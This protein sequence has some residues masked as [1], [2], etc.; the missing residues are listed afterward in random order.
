MGIIKTFLDTILS[1]RVNGAAEAAVTNAIEKASDWERAFQTGEGFNILGNS[2]KVTDAFGQVPSVFKAVMA[3]TDNVPQAEIK[4][5][6][7]NDLDG[8]PIPFDRL[9]K[10]LQRLFTKPNTTMNIKELMQF[11]AGFMS[12]SGEFMVIKVKSKGQEAGTSK[13]PAELI[14]DSPTKFKEKKDGAGKRV[15][16]VY[17]NA[18]Y[19]NDEV[20]YARNFNNVDVNRGISPNKPLSVILDTDLSARNYNKKFFDNDATPSVILSTDQALNDAQR[21]R[22]KEWWRKQFQGLKNAF[23][24]AVLEKGLKAESLGPSH[25]DMLFIKQSQFTREEILGTYRAPKALFNITDDLNYATFVGQMKIFWL[26]TLAPLLR[27]IEYA[28]NTDLVAQLNGNVVMVFD[29]SNVPAFKEDFGDKVKTAKELQSMGFK[30]NDINRRLNLGMEEVPW[31]EQWWIPFSTVPAGSVPVSDEDPEKSVKDNGKNIKGIDPVRVEAMFRMRH[32]KVEKKFDAALKAYFFNQRKL[33]LEELNSE[34]TKA[35]Q[36]INWETQNEKL[37]KISLPHITE[38]LT[39]GVDIA[40]ILTEIEA[41]EQVMSA[42]LSSLA[43]QRAQQITRINE[44]VQ[45]QLNLSLNEGI[46]AGETVQQISDRVRNVYNV[47]G[48]RAKLI[49]RTETTNAMNSASQTYYQEVGVRKKQWLT[50]GDERVRASHMAVNGEVVPITANFSN[51]V[52]VPGV[53]P[54]PA[55]VVNCR[56]TILP[57]IE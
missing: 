17:K 18:E 46:E 13:A 50:A 57:V 7:K 21:N 47:A 1:D 5:Y 8:E 38:A 55:E 31:G 49:A 42:K 26:Y 40:L 12:L 10:D 34:K 43:T 45:G 51:G 11:A 16:W 9:D 52:H 6:N 37:I 33:V 32:S 23:K 29:F 24:F 41:N 35:V 2:T 54:D 28:F 27:K 15:G 48:N 22:V 4:F 20:I 56:C 14:I 25:K 53:G 19:D 44:T 39:S 36:K 30:L 3:I